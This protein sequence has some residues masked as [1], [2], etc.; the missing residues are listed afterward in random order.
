MAK[1]LLLKAVNAFPVSC[2]LLAAFQLAP[3][4]TNSAAQSIFFPPSHPSL[5]LPS[6]KKIKSMASTSRIFL[7]GDTKSPRNEFIYYTSRGDLEGLRQGKY[8]VLIKKNRRRKNQP[9]SGGQVMLFD[10]DSDLGEK[11]NLADK[12]P[13]IVA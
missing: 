6:R 2:G 5:K 1:V 10:L 3:L 4:A 13:E 11:T 8:K 12:H 9:A 7:P